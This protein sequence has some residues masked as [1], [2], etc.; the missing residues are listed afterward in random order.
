VPWGSVLD[1]LPLPRVP[2]ER[3]DEE[4]RVVLVDHVPEKVRDVFRGKVAWE[5]AV[6]VF[7]VTGHPRAT[8]AY[9]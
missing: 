1:D 2:L 7:A 4:V 5:G 6:E 9:A 8:T 3:P